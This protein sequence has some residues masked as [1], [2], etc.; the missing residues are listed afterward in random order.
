L[1]NNVL[2]FIG[3]GIGGVLRYWVANIIYYFFGRQFPYGTLVVNVSGCFLMGLLYILTL[4]RF[5]GIGS[6]LRA[7]LLIG[8]LGGYTTFSSFSVE[9]INLFENGNYVSALTNIV[10]ST[11]ASIAAAWLGMIWGRSL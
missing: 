1:I 5:D 11:V 9:T 3:A 7:L 10:F 2:I 8:L 4:E 6:Q